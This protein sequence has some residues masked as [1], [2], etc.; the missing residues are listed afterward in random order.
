M[1]IDWRRF[2]FFG[3]ILAV[4]ASASGQPKCKVEFYTTEQG[5]SHQAV[6]SILKDQE[7]FMW[8]GSWDGI[9][10]FDGHSFVAYKSSPGDMSQ[11][12]NDRIDQ[13]VEDQ[14]GHLWI[15]A[16]DK[17]IY[18]FDKKTEQFHPI[19]D[20]FASVNNEKILFNRILSTNDGLVWL[21][22]SEQGV[23]SV[24]QN[25]LSKKSITKYAAGENVDFRLP[26][27]TINF[28]HRDL[29]SAIWAGTTK[30]LSHLVRSPSG[31]YING[32][33]NLQPTAGKNYTAVD[34]D[35]K[36]LFFGSADGDIIIFDKT[37]KT[38]SS[39]KISAG[40]INAVFK[41][42]KNNDNLYVTTSRGELICFDVARQTIVNVN[43]QS[44]SALYSIYEDEQGFLWIEPDKLGAVRYNPL[45]QVMQFF[46]EKN[47]EH[48]NVVGNRF[49]V[50]QDNNGLIWVNM[51]GGGF[52]Y[53]DPK[54][55]SIQKFL[56]T[57]DGSVYRLPSIVYTIFF[58]SAGVLWITT[59][60]RQL[61]KI[62]LQGNNFRQNL[63]VESGYSR[64]DNE[65]RGML[66]DRQDRL[67]VGT[68]SGKLY[69]FK[70]DKRIEGLFDNQPEKGIGLVY[71]MLQDSKGNIWLGT[72]GNGLYKA[73]PIGKEQTKY[74]LTHFLPRLN[75]NYSLNCNEI[76]SLLE[77]RLGRI[78]IG[79]FDQGLTLVQQYQ[80]SVRFIHSGNLF[81]N[82]PKGNFHK[83]RHMTLDKEGNIWIG[84]TAGLV[85]LKVD[86]RQS[87][88]YQYVTYSKIQGNRESLANNDV[89]FIRRD[90]KNRMWLATSGG[91]IC[92]AKG[93]KIFDSLKFRNYTSKDG[94]PNDYILSCAEDNKGYLWLATENG[95]S[96]FQ[97]DSG[98]FK[99]YDS[100]DG[101]SRA[102]FSEAAVCQQTQS[103]QL[104]FG[105]SKGYLAFN[106]QD[107]SG[108]RIKANL[109]F[110]NLQIN[111]EEVGPLVKESLLK[112]NINYVPELNL[113]YNQNTVIIDYSILDYRAGSRQE[114]VYRLLGFDNEWHGDGNQRRVTYTN[115]SPGHYVF[116]IKSLNNDLYTNAPYRRLSIRI[117]PPPW[118]TWWADSLYVAFAILVLSIIRRYAIAMIRL[119]NKIAV[120]QK[121]TELKLHF[122][123]NI[124]H[125]LRTPLT[126]I[127]NPLEEVL[128]KEKLSVRGSAYVEV[129]R[130]NANRMVR[131][132]NQLLD[133]RKIQSNQATLQIS[134]L[135]IV[136]FVR[137]VCD[138]FTEAA[139]SKRISLEIIAEEK[140]IIAWVDA[141]KLD[142]VIYNL[143]GN[144]IKFTPAGKNIYVVIKLLQQENCFSI[145][146]CDQGPGVKKDKLEEIFELFH[147][148]DPAMDRAI[149]GSGIGLALS[150]E[151]VV[152][153][154]GTIWAE[155]N[156]D[157]GLNVILKM[158]I[159]SGH[160]LNRNVS[161][162][163]TKKTI[164]I[165]EE[166]PIEQQI[167][168]LQSDEV[169]QKD[170]NAPLVLLVEDN[171]ELR[172]FL[173]NQLSEL[174]RVEVA[175]DG[176][177]GWQKAVNL[178]PEL[179]VS[180]IMM[181]V[182]DGIQLLDK[183]KNDINTSHIPVVLLSAKYSIESQIEG[184]KYG[185]D[186]YITKPFNNEFLIVSINNLLRQ[187]K[188]LFESLVQK[189]KTLSLA[190]GLIVVTSKD[191][192]FLKDVI[193]TVEEKMADTEFNIETVA[194]AMAMSR[195]TFY[196]KFKSLTGMAPIEFVRDMRLQ[197]AKQFLDAGGNNVAD[198]AYL[199]GFANPKYFSTCF[200]EKYRVSPSEYLKM[201]AEQS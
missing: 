37:A 19:A 107:V 89:Q 145:A 10:R 200:K 174:Y 43:R 57:P 82:Y 141:E 21:L 3:L 100:Y 124:S 101:L 135:E 138:H 125:E 44:P 38:F 146:I 26:S 132:I 133:L 98:I 156:E 46:F 199:V 54:T 187:R 122:F 161:F 142:V 20:Y 128:K 13:I 12:G 78:W 180:D 112:D 192:V 181:P 80:D 18:R 177:E 91:G 115:L 93:D 88:L 9:N 113:R 185:A 94:L 105:T 148:G 121:L 170:H 151:F 167:L 90:S 158:K 49:K 87:P 4:F 61:I 47:A 75:D 42:K 58:D 83:I 166:T 197:R 193:R 186:Y 97:A 176:E 17:Q 65:V 178:V 84:T 16:Y 71:S 147:E 103:G 172:Q 1:L 123:T 134:R 76:Y 190:P 179:I 140:E 110:T 198:V 102:N 30:G 144:A 36:H 50:L 64:A 159:G 35:S 28:W 108:N 15:Q 184:L 14:S 95:L 69:V 127:V 60:E 24:Q 175:K 99:N 117:M 2:F 171:A 154:G 143:L 86:N 162:V 149:K 62:I 195:T 157:G 31:I 6:T 182:M 130:K 52:G 11:L 114:L 70:N 48:F 40:S 77:D 67:W 168:P 137:N 56:N 23:F 188:R 59:D 129:A 194:E 55:E 106:P 39:Q 196:K 109:V 27:N 131:F 92:L 73:S 150:K 165:A 81:T 74:H 22:S 136:S 155:N 163:N 41:S 29:E 34:E 7:G 153:H 104:V 183:V 173:K 72:K 96:E 189:K 116:E 164:S 119:R 25:E 120:E 111:N 33:L 160:Y 63:L 8:F 85:I 169:F 5:L 139:R 152:L 201:K 126:L 191:E 32:S 51:K 45:K 66:W 79:S 68:K 118:K 53:F